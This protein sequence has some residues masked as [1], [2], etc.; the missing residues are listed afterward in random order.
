MSSNGERDGSVVPSEL[1]ILT[2][3]YN[4]EAD[5]DAIR[6]AYYKSASGDPETYPVQFAVLL[7]A[8]AQLLKSYPGMLR[9]VF[10]TETKKLVEGAAMLAKTLPDREKIA[11][12][13]R[14]A[15]EIRD[16]Y[17]SLNSRGWLP[18]PL[19]HK[20]GIRLGIAAIVG[21]I[22]FLAGELN[23]SH[24]ANDRIEAVVNAMPAASR[25]PLYLTGQGGGISLGRITAADGRSE[26]QGIIIRPGHLKFGQPTFSTDGN[27]LVPIQ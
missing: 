19:L 1:S 7:T 11:E 9:K 20:W 14:H 24:Q 23:A 3:L 4:D 27:A 25:V 13:A 17:K 26:S 2:D 21:V 5:R 18:E 8:N 10:E 16:A 22:A 6:R 15:R 12:L